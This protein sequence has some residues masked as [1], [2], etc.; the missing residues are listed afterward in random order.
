MESHLGPGETVQRGRRAASWHSLHHLAGLWVTLK[1]IMKSGS[2]QSTVSWLKQTHDKSEWDAQQH[3]PRAD[4]VPSKSCGSHLQSSSVTSFN[5][6]RENGSKMKNC[7]G[8]LMKGS[9]TP[10]LPQPC[11]PRLQAKSQS[12][13]SKTGH[14]LAGFG[15]Q[16]DV[17]LKGE[18][19]RNR[20]VDRSQANAAQSG[21]V[22]AW[23]SSLTIGWL[24]QTWPIC[25]HTHRRTSCMTKFSE[26]FTWRHTHT[27]G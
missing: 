3:P 4:R 13:Q 25:V 8:T 11:C 24:L 16:P 23:A 27:H 26:A 2:L 14:F 22:K 10:T 6:R 9:S 20:E 7:V 12:K 17:A 15:T 19:T 18:I 21:H 1:R 5:Y